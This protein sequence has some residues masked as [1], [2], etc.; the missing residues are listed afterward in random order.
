[1]FNLRVNCSDKLDL[2]TG[3]CVYFYGE[4]K[5]SNIFCHLFKNP[6]VVNN[7]I[8]VV[9]CFPQCS[10]PIMAQNYWPKEEDVRALRGC[11]FNLND[12][13]R[14]TRLN[15]GGKVL[16]LHNVMM[17]SGIGVSL[18]RLCQRR[19]SILVQLGRFSLFSYLAGSIRL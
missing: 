16:N 19:L 17:N 4:D 12:R 14:P 15:L 6:F 18:L 5:S 10:Y 11:S 8:V 1:V 9:E 7:C 13:H 3:D 2:T